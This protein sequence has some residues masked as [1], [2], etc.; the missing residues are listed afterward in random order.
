MIRHINPWIIEQN[1]SIL[2]WLEKKQKHLICLFFFFL[3]AAQDVGGNKASKK[4]AI[5]L[6]HM[7]KLFVK[8]KEG[9][10]CFVCWKKNKWEDQSNSIC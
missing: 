1:V 3:D 9:K 10:N 6:E 5:D 4:V 7:A 2:V 8:E